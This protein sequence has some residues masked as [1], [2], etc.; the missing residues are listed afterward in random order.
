MKN[1]FKGTHSGAITFTAAEAIPANTPVKFNGSGQIVKAAA[2][3]DVAIGSTIDGATGAGDIVAVAVFG[4]HPGTVAVIAGAG[5]MT[6]GSA[7][8]PIGTKATTGLTIGI[9]LSDADAG[10][11]F[12]LAHK[13]AV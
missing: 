6:Q 1:P 2:A 7:V 11:V 5:G 4:A 10:K 9:A 8:T 3:T 13:P 12:E